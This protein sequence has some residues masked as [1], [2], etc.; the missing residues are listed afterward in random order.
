METTAEDIQID[1]RTVVVARPPEPD[2]G[3]AW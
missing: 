3:R 1:D 2:R